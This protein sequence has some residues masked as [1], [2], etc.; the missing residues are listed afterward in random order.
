MSQM[1]MPQHV[2]Y[3]AAAVYLGMWM[4]MMVPMMLPSLV[5]MLG[6]YR[7]S[8]RGVNGIHLNGLT[9]L[10]GVGYFVVWGVLGAAA[11]AIGAGVMAFEMRWEILAHWMPLAAGLVLLVAG[12]VQFTPWK[13]RQLA[14]CRESRGCGCPPTPG[15]LGAWRHGL[16]LGLRCSLCCGSLMLALLAVGM[17][18]LVAMALVTLAISAERLAPVPLR[19]ARAA[20]VAIVL[21]GVLTIV[22]V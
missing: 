11:Y 17:M 12:G 19:V 21:A 15:A 2:W 13:A 7:R 9:A 20:G 5:P 18:N 22:R 14:L 6:R 10:V 3:V 4:A 1:P 8:V 16:R